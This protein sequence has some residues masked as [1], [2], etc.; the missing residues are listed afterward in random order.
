MIRNGK[1]W[2]TPLPGAHQKPSQSQRNE[3]VRHLLLEAARLERSPPRGGGLPHPDRA[4]KK[5]DVEVVLCST[6]RAQRRAE[7]HELILDEADGLDWPTLCKC[8][9]NVVSMVSTLSPQFES[10]GWQ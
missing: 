7:P 9:L 10:C 5:P 2:N 8:D 1:R 4:S 6:Q 3:T